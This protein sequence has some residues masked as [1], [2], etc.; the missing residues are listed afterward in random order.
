MIERWRSAATEAE[1]ELLDWVR[2]VADAAA[3]RTLNRDGV[4]DPAT[5]LP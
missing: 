5:A 1:Q 4:S 2:C 3:E